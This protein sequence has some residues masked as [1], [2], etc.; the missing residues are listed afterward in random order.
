MAP[1]IISTILFLLA[2]RPLSAHESAL[3]PSST[4]TT[5]PPTSTASG[6][7]SPA[8]KRETV[9]Y[10]SWGNVLEV[11]STGLK[12]IAPNSSISIASSSIQSSTAPSLV[13]ITGASPTNTL[14]ATG[15]ST[16]TPRPSNTRPCN[17]YVELC[18][19]KLSNVSLVVAHNSPFVVPHNAASN[20]VYPVLNQ[21]AD[22]VRGCESSV[23][24]T[25]RNYS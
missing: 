15:A 11:S 24:T 5:L 12:S 9:E 10:G 3:I 14:N 13:G 23:Q 1:S 8:R 7:F 21:L 22:G 6:A 4:L 19:R 2:A 16:S 25:I 18:D 17:G 20:Q